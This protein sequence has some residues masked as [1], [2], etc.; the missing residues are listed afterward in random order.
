MFCLLLVDAPAAAAALFPGSDQDAAS[1][2]WD[3]IVNG[4]GWAAAG[5]V[6]AALVYFLRKYDTKIPKVGPQIDAF[7]NQPLVAFALPLVVSFFG[8]AGTGLA[9]SEK[10]GLSLKA[11]LLPALF[12]ALKVTGS[13]AFQ[14]LLAKNASEQLAGAQA[15]GDAAAVVAG[16]TKA[17]AIEEL[18]KP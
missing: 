13:A 9:A 10:T 11:S 4:K 2:I 7:L 17:A 16:A 18:K 1:W 12:G 14:F 8:A 15:S 6:V 3:S 5:T